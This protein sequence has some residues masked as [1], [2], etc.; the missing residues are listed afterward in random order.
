MSCGLQNLVCG[1]ITLSVQAPYR[2]SG[3]RTHHLFLARRTRF[4]PNLNPISFPATGAD[5]RNIRIVETCRGAKREE[6]CPFGG[7]SDGDLKVHPSQVET[8][9]QFAVS[10][11]GLRLQYGFFLER[12]RIFGGGAGYGDINQITNR[13]EHSWLGRALPGENNRPWTYF[14][15]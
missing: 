3:C 11:F 1:W 9:S 8:P 4:A 10:R 5:N 2:Q 7:P 12:G 6:A 13:A 14:C 15:L